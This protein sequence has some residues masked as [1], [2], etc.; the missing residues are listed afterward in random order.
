MLVAAG[1]GMCNMVPRL[2]LQQHSSIRPGP[3]ST[4]TTPAWA[5]WHWGIM[6]MEVMVVVV[7]MPRP[8]CSLV[9]THLQHPGGSRQGGEAVGEEGCR[10]L[11]PIMDTC[12]AGVRPGPAPQS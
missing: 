1:A 8:C 11:A 6:M 10:I 2:S 12:R 4:S 9:Y 3:C 7:L 5:G